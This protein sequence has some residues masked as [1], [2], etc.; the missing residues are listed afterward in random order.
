M[1]VT[2]STYPVPFTTGAGAS[3]ICLIMGYW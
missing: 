2:G 3:G 1:A